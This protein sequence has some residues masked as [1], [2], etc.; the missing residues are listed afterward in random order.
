MQEEA[1]TLIGMYTL[2]SGSPERVAEFRWS[3]GSGVSVEVFESDWGNLARV[4]YNEGVLLVG[5]QR[6][7][8]ASEGAEFM[9]AL[10]ERKHSGYYGFVDESENR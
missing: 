3:P 7:V 2:A 6:R 5:E 8:K 1:P 4:F 9:R 10:L